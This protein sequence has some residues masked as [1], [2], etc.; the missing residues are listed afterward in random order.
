MKRETQT[1]TKSALKQSLEEPRKLSE[2]L[3][4][5]KARRAPMSVDEITVGSDQVLDLNG[6]ILGKPGSRNKAIEQLMELQGVEHT[7][8][9]AV[10][11]R[12]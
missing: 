12:R 1:S 5:L 11:F 7:L 8:I 2:E 3:A 9:T 10:R 4:K 6:R